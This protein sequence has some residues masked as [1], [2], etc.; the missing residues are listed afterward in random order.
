MPRKTAVYER[1]A[2]GLVLRPD[3]KLLMIEVK[4][5]LGEIVWTFPKGHLE[6]G[7]TDAEAALREVLE[8]TGWRCEIVARGRRKVFEKV[9]YGFMRGDRKV[10]K[11]VIWF[12]MKPAGKKGKMDPEEV[13]KV[14]WASP[15]EAREKATYPSD[16]KLLKKL[17]S[18]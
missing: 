15:E 2:G 11:D 4:N 10:R 1:S 18:V 5:L 6:K 9:S 16:Q 13:R 7:E 14:K 8:E 3:G 12:L 17:A